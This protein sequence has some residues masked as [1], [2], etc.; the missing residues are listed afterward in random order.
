M[1]KITLLT[2]TLGRSSKR[3]KKETPSTEIILS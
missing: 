1:L 3:E 2:I